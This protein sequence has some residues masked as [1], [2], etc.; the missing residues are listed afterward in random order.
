MPRCLSSK[1]VCLKQMA[2]VSCSWIQV[3]GSQNPLSLFGLTPVFPSSLC[4]CFNG[5]VSFL[6]LSLFFF[7]LLLQSTLHPPLM[8]P[9]PE[10]GRL[11]SATTHISTRVHLPFPNSPCRQAFEAAINKQAHSHQGRERLLSVPRGLFNCLR[12]TCPRLRKG[13]GGDFPTLACFSQL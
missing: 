13:G 4:Y 8:W 2:S 3:P 1:V 12:S 9:G 7:F 11:R 5:G 10:V 6:S